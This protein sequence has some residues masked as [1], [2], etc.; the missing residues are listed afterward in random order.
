MS[1]ENRISLH[2]SDDD[3]LEITNAVQILQ[4]KLRPYLINLSGEERMSLAKMGDRNIAFIEKCKEY[5]EQNPELTP[6]YISFEEMQVD[7]DAVEILRKLNNPVA[8]IS[9]AI[10]DTMM[11]SGSEAY[12]AALAYYYHVKG[13][14]RMKMPGAQ[15]IYDELKKQF[16]KKTNNNVEE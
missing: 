8:Q 13:A 12:M 6:N 5:I 7:L 3:L 10:N 4:S 16:I 15:T 11:L 1:Q 2:I 14:A 9:A